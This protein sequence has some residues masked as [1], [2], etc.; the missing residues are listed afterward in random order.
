MKNEFIK[1][2]KRNNSRILF[3]KIKPEMHDSFYT[4]LK[5]LFSLSHNKKFNK[6]D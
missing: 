5:F 1:R 6:V 3:I 2:M 4:F